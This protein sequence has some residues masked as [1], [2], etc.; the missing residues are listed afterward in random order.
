[1]KIQGFIESTQYLLSAAMLNLIVLTSIDALEQEYRH[2][3]VKDLVLYLD[4]LFLSYYPHFRCNAIVVLVRP[5]NML[6]KRMV[7]SCIAAFVDGN[8]VL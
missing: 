5:V 6:V 2:Y 1:M 4:N 3:P 7:N 8:F